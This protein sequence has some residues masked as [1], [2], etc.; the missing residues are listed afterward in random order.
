MINSSTQQMG[1]LISE[2]KLEH[3]EIVGYS[4]MNF[5]NRSMN[6]PI[7]PCISIAASFPARRTSS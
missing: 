7:R 5:Y 3:I 4:E 1:F 6:A 2:R